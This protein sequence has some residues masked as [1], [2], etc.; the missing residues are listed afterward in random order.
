M[1]L[2]MFISSCKS[3]PSCLLTIVKKL[4]RQLIGGNGAL[5]YVA[6]H[7][8]HNDLQDQADCEPVANMCVKI[9]RNAAL[10]G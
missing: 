3:C 4:D 10:S 6:S 1:M 8:K 5:L 2:T 9:G 7:L